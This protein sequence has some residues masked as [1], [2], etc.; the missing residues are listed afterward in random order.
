M[1][2]NNYTIS[3]CFRTVI[4]RTANLVL[5]LGKVNTTSL[6]KQ[7]RIIDQNNQ[8]SHESISEELMMT[9]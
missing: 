2:S 8:T 9:L 5:Y 7:T 3:Q 6:T 1:P 4:V